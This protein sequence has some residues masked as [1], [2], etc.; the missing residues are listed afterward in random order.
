MLLEREQARRE[1]AK[2]E[3][4]RTRIEWSDLEVGVVL[5]EGSFGRVK[6]AL[7]PTSGQ[8]YAL[9]CMRKGQLARFKQVQ[10]VV[11]EKRI[12]ALCDH[13][14]ILKLVRTFKDASS[15]AG[16]AHKRRNFMDFHP[17]IARMH[18]KSIK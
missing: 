14:F 6:L 13:P 10:H 3:R 12:L 7:H 11:N 15:A 16:I 1:A 4:E 17:K 2:A 9:K 5:G 8:A 18:T